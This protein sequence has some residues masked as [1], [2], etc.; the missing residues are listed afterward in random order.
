MPV[1]RGIWLWM[2]IR[3]RIHKGNVQ[4]EPDW[5]ACSGYAARFIACAQPR[6]CS[7]NVEVALVR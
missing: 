6:I 7:M 2:V 3:A 5:T 1:P 4:G